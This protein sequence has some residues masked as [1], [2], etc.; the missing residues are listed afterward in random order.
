M[1]GNDGIIYAQMT[2]L[3]L[4]Q[5]FFDFWKQIPRN[6]VQIPSSPLVPENDPTTLFTG[7]GMQPMMPYLLGAEHPLGTRLVDIQKCFRGQDIDE[8]GDNRHDSFF[9]MMGNWSLGDYFKKEQ[10]SW[11]FEFLT[12]VL[13]LP[14]ERLYVSV[15]GGDSQFNKD[16]ETIEIWKSLGVADDHIRPYGAKKNWWSRSGTPEEMPIGEPGGPDSEVFFDFDPDG[17][18]KIHEQ[19]QF[20]KQECHPNCDCGRFFEIGNNVFMTYLKTTDGFVPLKKKNIDFGGGVE[21][22][23]AAIND[24]PDIFKSDLYLPIIKIV[25]NYSGKKFE[26][27]SRNFRI[28]ADHLKAAVFLIDAGVT[29]SNKDRGYI[30]RRLIRRVTRFG[31]GLGIEQNLGIQAC[32]TVIEIYQDPYPSLAIN[33]KTIQ[34]VISEEENK[35]RKTVDNGLREFERISTKGIVSASDAFYLYES[36]GF[37]FELTEEEAKNKNLDVPSK[38]EF[39]L[40]VKKHQ[41]LSRTAAAGMFKG[42]LADH[43]EQVTKYHTATHLLQAALRQVLGTHVHQEGSNLTGERL[44]FDFSQPQKLTPDEIKKVADIVNEQI[45]ADLQ[46]KVET[47]TYDEAVKSGAMAFFKERYPEKVTVYSFGSFSKEI[48]GGPHVEHTG[49]LGRFK[50]IKEEAVSAG[51]RRIYA[52]LG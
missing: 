7:S 4:R 23:L 17:K 11:Y 43:S 48:C 21:R 5:K 45:A 9:E 33:R 36:F 29:P 31:R 22:T 30:L 47:M 32:E 27:Q 39:N 41:D 15:F 10:V 18:R 50:I 3:E 2:H 16:V 34:Q 19:S 42:G 24:D 20:S 37:P 40:E 1:P 14:K 51:V 38:E 46:R 35:F 8:V 52:V 28:I 6:H 26:E 25:E 49:I 44:R 13:G 12:K